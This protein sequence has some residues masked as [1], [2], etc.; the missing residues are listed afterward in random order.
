MLNISKKIRLIF[1][2]LLIALVLPQTALAD[3]TGNANFSVKAELPENQV[4]KDQTYFD[5]RMKPGEKQAISLVLDNPS[6]EPVSV[7]VQPNVA[8]TNQN[9]E[10]DF[11]GSN[12][13]IDNSLTHVFT[14]L[15]SKE[16][17]VELAAN[18]TKKVTFDLTMPA[19]EFQGIVLGGF[20]IYK[21]VSEEEEKAS[22]N[23][24]IKNR[25]SYVIGV[26]LSM[27]DEEVTPEVVLNEIKPDLLNY[28]TIVTANLQNTMPTMIGKFKVDAKVYN[29]AGTELLHET[30]KEAMTMAPN[31]NFGFPISWDNQRLEPGTYLLKLQASSGDNKW[32]FDQEFTIS[33]TDSKKLNEEA[34][35]LEEAGINWYLII[36]SGAVILAVIIGGIF[37]YQS[38]KDKKRASK[39]R[40][41]KK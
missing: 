6:D 41:N 4:D 33:A 25:Y 26:Q 8:T 22:E 18:E 7:T 20:Y 5:L 29:K 10:M 36:G 21:N 38:K 24:Q 1:G 13:D 28:R 27:N 11:S 35:E 31:S 15:I 34:V 40:T 12:T 16:Q 9:G 37:V 14:D 3:G 30:I 23:V 17:T 2:V 39:K 19:E 32:D